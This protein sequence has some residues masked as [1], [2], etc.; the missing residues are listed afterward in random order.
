MQI[1]ARE[2]FAP[3]DLNVDAQMAQHQG[4]AARRAVRLG[5]R[6]PAGTLF[7]GAHDVGLDV[8]TVTSPGN[9]N[10]AF[11]KQYARAAPDGA[12][13]R[14]RSRI[15]ASDAPTDPATKTALAN[16]TARSRRSAPS[17]T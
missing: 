17:P 6:R 12:A 14:R 4:R 15:Y 7:R 9:L 10:A 3:G 5:D 16:M 8:P 13:L 1:V 2:H 11:F